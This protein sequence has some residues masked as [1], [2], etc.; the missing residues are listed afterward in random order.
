MRREGV[1]QGFLAVGWDAQ[2]F[3]SKH[4]PII[5]EP[6]QERA[7]EA[8]LM[9]CKMVSLG[10]MASPVTGLLR[11]FAPLFGPLWFYLLVALLPRPSHIGE[12]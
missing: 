1:L 8:Q 11:S 5:R 7:W 12:S 3:C 9:G 2:A 4:V 6:V 10:T